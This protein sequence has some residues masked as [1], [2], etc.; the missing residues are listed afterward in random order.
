MA[1]LGHL[2][3]SSLCQVAPALLGDHRADLGPVFLEFGR[4]GDDVLDNNLR[5]HVAAPLSAGFEKLQPSMH[6]G[7]LFL[8]RLARSRNGFNESRIVTGTHF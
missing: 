5:G 3:A 7:A 4:V 6:L 8:W 2:V 1:A